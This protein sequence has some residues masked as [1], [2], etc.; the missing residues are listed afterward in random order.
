MIKINSKIYL[1]LK[2]KKEV[3]TRDRHLKIINAKNIHKVIEMDM[4]AQVDVLRIKRGPRTK[5]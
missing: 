5:T 2:I 1:I 4:T 3:R